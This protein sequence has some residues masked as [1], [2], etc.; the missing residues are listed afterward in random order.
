MARKRLPV[1]ADH[2]PR[3][4]SLG[5]DGRRR[6]PY[7]ADVHGRFT[8]ARRVLRWALLAILFALPWLR[9]GGRPALLLD[10]A[11]RQF[12]LFGASFN[13]QDTP[14]LF[15]VLTGVGFGLVFVTALF[16]RV[17][18]GWAC[19]QT[20]FLEGLFRPVERWLEGPRNVALERRRRGMTL[21]LGWRLGLKY[22]FYTFLSVALAH[23]FLAYFVPVRELNAMLRG[24]PGLHPEAFLWMLGTTALFLVNFGVFREQFCVVM[25]PY[26]RLQS[27][28]LDD[29]SW[30]VGYDD[31][32]GEPRGKA[33][34]KSEGTAGDCVDCGRCVAVCPTGIDIREGLQLDC[35]ACT[36]CI[37][38]CDEVMLK[39]GRPSG[40]VRYDSAE[41]FAGRARRL[42]RPRILGYTALLLIGAV[43]A[44]LTLRS[45]SDFEATILR[46]PGPPY[47]QEA[48]LLRNG[49]ELHLVNKSGAPRTLV[50]EAD[51][52][53]TLTFLI[54]M[55]EVALEPLAHQRLPFFVTMDR[56]SFQS[57]QSFSIR[58][59]GSTTK[60]ATAR[61][62]GA[63]P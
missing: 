28:L 37:D 11:R 57:D 46:L 62:V 53:P 48:S 40:L 31:R 61:F 18:C 56:A 30:I 35:V 60:I 29:H 55:H 3:E 26:G 9:I 27:V 45:R 22:A 12:F 38:A 52:D 47:Q 7:P 10:V 63:R 14:L 6:A 50:V 34:K 5:R 24:A 58:V 19:P 49:F 23:L 25:C 44:G 43:V 39:L 54:P 20:V 2:A 17:F 21:D 32:R 51:A 8:T 4:G 42:V 41:G 15:F 16:G 33:A 59:R 13:A 36:Q 1:V